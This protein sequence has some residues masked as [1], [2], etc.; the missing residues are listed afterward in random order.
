M[1]SHDSILS[2]N[3]ASGKPGAVQAPRKLLEELREVKSL[4]VILPTREK[5]LRLRMVAT[6]SRELKVLLQRMK[7]LLPNRPKIIENV[8]KKMAY[9]ET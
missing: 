2:Q 5:K 9:F 8:V 3:G 1:R 4:D 6:P 7:I